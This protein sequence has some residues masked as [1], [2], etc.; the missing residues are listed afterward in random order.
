MADYEHSTTAATLAT[1]PDPVRAALLE[2]ARTAL[3][4]MASVAKSLLLG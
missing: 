3:L 4:T 1:L 2:R